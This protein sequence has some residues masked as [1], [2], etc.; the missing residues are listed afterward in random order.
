MML[1]LVCGWLQRD[2]ALNVAAGLHLPSRDGGFQYSPRE[3]S[4]KSSSVQKPCHGFKSRCH[5]A[6]TE[7][8]TYPNL[9]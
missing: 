6:R 1:R 3:P 7:G 9:F 8:K 2:E 5:W 4:N